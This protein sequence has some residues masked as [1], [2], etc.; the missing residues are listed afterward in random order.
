MAESYSLV[1]TVVQVLCDGQEGFEDPWR[2]VFLF[3]EEL[4]ASLLLVILASGA[5]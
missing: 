2:E 5:I 3:F 4:T 1:N